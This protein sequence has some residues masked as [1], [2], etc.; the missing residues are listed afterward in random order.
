MF[1][2]LSQ[3]LQDLL[4]HLA[5][6]N[7]HLS[8]DEAMVLSGAAFRHY[9]FS[10]IDN[11]AWLVEYPDDH[12]RNDTLR[13]ENY[14]LYESIAGHTGWASRQWSHLTGPEFIQLL[15][16]EHKNGRVLRI[17][18]DAT[19][20]G[21]F[22]IDH[23]VG[24]NGV[25]LTVDR[26]G[27]F[28]HLSH[29]DLTTLSDFVQTLGVLQSLRLEEPDDIPIRRQHAL[30]HDVLRWACQHHVAKKEIMYDVQAFYAAGNRA[31]TLLHD[32]V[33]SLDKLPSEK[34]AAA[35]TYVRA[36]LHEIG[37]ARASAARFFSNEAH[38]EK[39]LA[40]DLIHGGMRTVH[41][42]WKASAD[43][44]LQAASS[45]DTSMTAA[46]RNAQQLDANAF[47]LFARALDNA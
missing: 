4:Q 31:W 8:V 15:A 47:D 18:A 13:V 28:E 42:A 7:V 40:A 16:Y 36:H 37:L 34:H 38:I 22:I 41:H 6:H 25:Q 46:I 33:N 23:R 20:H 3:A 5:R 1:L 30:T 9:F 39:H 24:R 2:T 19:S 45:Q 26:D 43:A 29:P 11:H 17:E 32:F 27:T 35:L 12:W 10:P 44:I 14:G 21:G